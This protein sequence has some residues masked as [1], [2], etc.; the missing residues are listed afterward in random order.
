MTS[1]TSR[2][3]TMM[4]THSSA[5]RHPDDRRST[6]SGGGGTTGVSRVGTLSWVGTEL[7]GGELNTGRSGYRTLS[8]PLVTPPVPAQDAAGRG[9][10]DG[11]VAF[12]HHGIGPGAQE[13]PLEP[14]PFAD[15]QPDPE[16]AA[17]AGL[18]TLVRVA[19]G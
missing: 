18:E 4:A 6:L 2:A 11:R 13:E 19:L 8:D 1:A 5:L 14:G 7:L 10:P 9:R 15:P 3:P 16:H 12:G 17:R